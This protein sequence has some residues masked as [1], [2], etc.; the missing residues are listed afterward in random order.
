MWNGRMLWDNV[1]IGAMLRV[2]VRSE[3]GNVRSE[4]GNVRSEC[5][6]GGM[7]EVNVLIGAN[8]WMNVR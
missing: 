8:I 4:C 5:G 2:D 6:N 1:L 3:C 7:L